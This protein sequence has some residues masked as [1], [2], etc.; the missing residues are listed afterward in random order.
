[1]QQKVYKKSIVTL[2]AKKRYLVYFLSSTALFKFKL[3]IITR[4]GVSIIRLPAIYLV[5]QI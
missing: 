3:R 1:M 2:I 5:T 4:K